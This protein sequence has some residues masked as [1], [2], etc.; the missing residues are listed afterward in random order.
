MFSILSHHKSTTYL[1]DARSSGWASC[2][3]Y[4]VIGHRVDITESPVAMDA[5]QL[6]YFK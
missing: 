5:G 6:S 4:A 1:S 3:V 2:V